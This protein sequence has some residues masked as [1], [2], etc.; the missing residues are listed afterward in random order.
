MS[1]YQLGRVGNP[2]GKLAHEIF[3]KSRKGIL[4]A[5]LVSLAVLAF[6]LLRM[7]IQQLTGNFH[8]VVPGVFY[9]SAQPDAQDIADYRARFGIKTIINLRNE[10]RGEW[11]RAEQK[12][13][14]DNG[15]DLIDF[16][17]SSAR[18]LS[19]EE[20]DRLAQVM[21]KAP[22][23]VLVHCEHGANRTGL[24]SAIY[25]A[26]EGGR[27]AGLQLSPLY[28]HVPIPGIGRYDLFRSWL[29]FQGVQSRSG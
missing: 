4:I 18:P 24:A 11:Y 23:P 22:K 3:R 1:L 27:Y 20:M 13:A 29:E 26:G 5:L 6:L 7:G 12:A 17:L 14:L 15:I 25:L 8:V 19:L 9:R 28:G 2:A 21:A 16:P 10:A